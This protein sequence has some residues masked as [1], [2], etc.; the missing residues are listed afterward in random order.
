MKL[1]INIGSTDRIIRF[2]FSLILV[3]LYYLGILNGMYGAI[4]L[5]IA[6]LLTTSSLISFCP[7]YS[8]LKA[9]T[10]TKKK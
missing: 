4:G 3:L 9:N 10:L 8:I 6:L 7:I 5:I 1:N 2:I